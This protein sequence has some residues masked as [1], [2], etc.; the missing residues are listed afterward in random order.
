MFCSLVFSLLN[1]SPLH[2]V[3]LLQI[4]SGAL[5][6]SFCRNGSFPCSTEGRDW[7][8]SFFRDTFDFRYLEKYQIP[9]HPATFS[10]S[11]SSSTSHTKGKVLSEQSPALFISR[12]SSW[13]DFGRGKKE[14]RDQGALH[15]PGFVETRVTA[16]F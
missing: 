1:G 10:F 11:T 4:P 6:G 3:L 16:S 8:R 13:S 5:P 2:L 9:S 7:R 14:E 12:V 15:C